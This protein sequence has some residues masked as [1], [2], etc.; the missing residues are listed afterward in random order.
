MVSLSSLSSPPPSLQ[1]LRGDVNLAW[2]TAQIAVMGAK[3]AVDILFRTNGANS[4]EERARKA[5]EYEA[6]FNAP[7]Q[8]AGL[9]YV[10]DVIL[11][12]DTRRRLCAELDA[13]HGKRRAAPKRKHSN[14]PL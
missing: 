12:R 8:A 7:F 4:K 14:M 9:G 2:P 10:D 6:R 11:P 13:L 1:H 3:G 5:A